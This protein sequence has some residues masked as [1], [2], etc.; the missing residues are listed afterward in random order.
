[1]SQSKVVR[2]AHA[3]NDP[4]AQCRLRWQEIVYEFL[5]D[6]FYGAEAF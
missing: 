4:P 1:M 5:G 6:D 3:K 2:K